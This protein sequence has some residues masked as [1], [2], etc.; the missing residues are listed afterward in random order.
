MKDINPTQGGSFKRR[1]DGSLEQ[2]QGTKPAEHADKRKRADAPADAPADA[3]AT[4]APAKPAK[5]AK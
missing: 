3:Q 5:A 4:P 1:A 2:V